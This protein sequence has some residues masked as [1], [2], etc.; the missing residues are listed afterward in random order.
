MLEN[1]IVTSMIKEVLLIEEPENQDHVDYS[2]FELMDSCFSSLIKI[3]S[4]SI[5]YETE[6]SKN[7]KTDQFMN[8]I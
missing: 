2:Y 8:C 5:L 1:E 7:Y 3:V 4:N 6:L